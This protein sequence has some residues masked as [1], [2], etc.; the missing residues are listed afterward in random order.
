[1]KYIVLIGDGMADM[2]LEAIGGMTPLQRAVTANMDALASGGIYGMVRTVPEGFPPG[3][4]VANLSILGYN[5]RDYYSGRAPLEAASMGLPL[6]KDD[7]A[8]R[9]NLVYLDFTQKETLMA[10]YSSGHITSEEARELI[11]AINRELGIDS[12]QFYPGISYRHLMVCKNGPIDMSCTPPHDITGRPVAAYLPQGQGADVL[13]TLMLKSQE[14]LKDH[15]VNI[16]R[17]RR[18]KPPAN[19]IWLWGQG[20]RPALPLFKDKYGIEG[21]LISA[22]DLTKGLGVCAGLR[23]IDVPGATGYI[24]TN[25]KGKA[26]YGVNSLK[27]RDFVYIHVEAPDEAGHSGRLDDKIRAI[28]DFDSIVVDE[29]LRLLKDAGDYKILLMPDH[30]TPIALKTHTNASVPFVI[31]DSRA[32]KT[33]K[34]SYD[35]GI[36]SLKDALYID[37]GHTLMSYFITGKR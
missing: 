3:S 4:D 6:D 30:P 5:P 23:I 2:P 33:N 19:S 18:G 35:E 36:G 27:D 8:F 34:I 14:I 21:S 31:Y 25:Y 22:V 9:C 12:I 24:D 26:A 7:A 17:I 37:E 13:L 20:R 15:P 28:E 11:L 10:D 29:V 16:D 32:V 1:M